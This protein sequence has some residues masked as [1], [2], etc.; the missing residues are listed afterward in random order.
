MMTLR[1]KTNADGS[2]GAT[3]EQILQL[4]VPLVVRLGE[5]TL[6]LAEVVSLLPGAILE[7]P[8]NSEE[9][10]DILVNNRL[11][12]RG[13]AVKVG[14]NFGIRITSIGPVRERVE[15]LGEPN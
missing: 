14:E 8:K 4:E 5:R 1:R 2:T 7:L 11:I 10:L 12:G 9:Q 6:G 3:L 13:L 15:A